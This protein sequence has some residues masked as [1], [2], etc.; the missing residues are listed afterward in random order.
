M[1]YN[2]IKIYYEGDEYSPFYLVKDIDLNPYY[3]D[4]RSG[5]L[6]ISNKVT[7]VSSIDLVCAENT[8][9]EHIDVKIK[10]IDNSKNPVYPFTGDLNINAT[11]A[12]VILRD[13]GIDIYGN[14]YVII[15]PTMEDDIELNISVN[16]VVVEKNIKII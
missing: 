12:N 7:N 9:G 3:N 4:I 8:K 16:D 2:S 14:F 11:N 10:L 15:E 13:E 6:F 1:D 5:Y